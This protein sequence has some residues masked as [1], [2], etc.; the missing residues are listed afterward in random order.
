MKQ[1]PPII[2]TPPLDPEGA[3]PEG[4]EGADTAEE[5][6]IRPFAIAAAL[7]GQRLDRA[8]AL[9][10]PEFSRSYLQQLIEDGAVQL[11]SRVARK[12][13]VAV[14]VGDAGN[15]IA[16]HFCPTCGSTVW[17]Q[18]EGRPEV[19]AIPVGAFA[20]PTFPPPTSSGY[21][22]RKHAWVVLPEMM[23]RLT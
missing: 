12:P 2:S 21:D 9:L 3:A 8:L 11:Q 14:R 20:D 10:V 15:R 17:Y 6:E 7:H 18:L 23:E 16:F 19:I 22:V 1:V 5:S 4:D 13:S